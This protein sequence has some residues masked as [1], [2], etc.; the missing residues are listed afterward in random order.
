MFEQRNRRQ[1]LFFFRTNLSNLL[2]QRIRFLRE[3]KTNRM[4][5]IFRRRAIL[6]EIDFLFERKRRKSEEKTSKRQ[7]LFFV[8][9]SAGRFPL[10]LFRLEIERGDGNEFRLVDFVS[11]LADF[12]GLK[13]DRMI[14]VMFLVEHSFDLSIEIVRVDPRTRLDLQTTNFLL[15]IFLTF[16]LF[17]RQ[18]FVQIRSDPLLLFELNLFVLG[19]FLQEPFVFLPRQTRDDSTER[20]FSSFADLVISINWRNSFS[21]AFS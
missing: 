17:V 5:D 18:D 3:K 2:T 21:S 6:R 8:F 16:D 4:S 13:I 11:V 7:F 12:V 9:R 1:K 19:T 10:N 20:D 15:E 14:V